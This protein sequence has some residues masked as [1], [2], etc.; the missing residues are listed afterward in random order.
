M[1][2][3]DNLPKSEDNLPK[4]FEFN[5]VEGTPVKII[6]P[7]KKELKIVDYIIAFDDSPDDLNDSIKRL[8]L[9]GYQPWGSPMMTVNY[10]GDYCNAQAMV[11]YED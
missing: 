1:N 7:E 8:I 6:M 10:S 11:K 9:N 4:S 5:K 2:G 3:E